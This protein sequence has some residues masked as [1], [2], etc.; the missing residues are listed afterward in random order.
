M[1]HHT[2]ACRGGAFTTVAIGCWIALAPP[3]PRAAQLIRPVAGFTAGFTGNV[4]GIGLQPEGGILVCGDLH[5][6]DPAY[7]R[8]LVRL[9]ANGQYDPS[10]EPPIIDLGPYNPVPFAVD[11]QG[12]ALLARQGSTPTV[13]RLLPDGH[14]DLSWTEQVGFEDLAGGA[15]VIRCLLALRDGSV[16]V[17]GRFSH[18]GG[19][20][21][22]CVA[23]LTPNGVLD[24][25]FNAANNLVPATE[26]LPT[27]RVMA[28]AE[29]GEG[30]LWIGGRL[31]PDGGY[32]EN[33]VAVLA[34][35]GE[36]VRISLQVPTVVVGAP[37]AGVATEHGFLLPDGW[38]HSFC[39]VSPSGLQAG[40]PLPGT[41]DVLVT[42]IDRGMAGF[43]R[44]PVHQPPPECEENCALG[45]KLTAPPS[46]LLP[47]D[48]TRFLAAGAF[49][50]RAYFLDYQGGNPKGM[51]RLPNGNMIVCDA[52][53]VVEYD[54]NGNV[55]RRWS[56]PI[57]GDPQGIT[58]DPQRDR[59][60]ML[61]N[62]FESLFVFDGEARFVRA[63]D[64]SRLGI[65]EPEGIE[66]HPANG[67]LLLVDD[68]V[69][70]LFEMTEEGE[71]LGWV[72]LA[73]VAGKQGLLATGAE[74]LAFDAANDRLFISFDEANWVGAFRFTPSS[75]PGGPALTLQSFF[76]G[77]NG[78]LRRGG[79]GIAYDPE[80][81][82]LWM[83]CSKW[84]RIAE[85][86]LDGQA[87]EQGFS[88]SLAMF[89]I[90]P[91]EPPPTPR[92]LGWR[93]DGNVLEVE[94][95]LEPLRRFSVEAAGTLP[96]TDQVTKLQTVTGS[97]AP[98]TVRVD[99]NPGE[100]SQFFRITEQP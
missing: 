81:D 48:G 54:R 78:I 45:F 87:V 16:L 65:D 3:E 33:L 26:E 98:R 57:L 37:T 18:A 15:P 32:G 10:Y 14:P 17:G 44:Q 36:V 77:T 31:T 49:D 79:D 5:A 20:P 1:S 95:E 76:R 60:Y 84:N 25:T 82:R 88:P 66:V 51:D 35:D 9:H 90:V 96:L 83:V 42:G 80:T 93:L 61:D 89:E 19:V 34:A 72:D 50:S 11:S 29:D 64:T 24:F 52:G 86:T 67:N 59:F 56:F 2:P 53:S 91:S 85:L 99:L 12:R 41:Q 22:Q 38:G 68:R 46:Y 58:Y 92:F 71:L 73:T 4:R 74:G 97:L 40:A 100:P 62:D 69:N 21:R 28:T 43:W 23:R 70:R 39:S 75:A 27:P 7:E 94:V 8:Q 13:F 63:L 30:N 6:G 55:V 47:L